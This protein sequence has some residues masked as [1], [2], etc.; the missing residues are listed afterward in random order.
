MFHQSKRLMV[1][2]LRESIDLG[3]NRKSGEVNTEV[4]LPSPPVLSVLFD[5]PQHHNNS[6][7]HC[8][9]QP[10]AGSPDDV[11]SPFHAVCTR[12]AGAE[13]AGIRA[14]L[15]LPPTPAALY[16]AGTE[17]SRLDNRR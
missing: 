9:R 6:S 12:S 3:E 13:H 8:L 4:V 2:L 16:L 7:F 14:Q 10:V 17:G 11:F 1:K 5:R 15:N